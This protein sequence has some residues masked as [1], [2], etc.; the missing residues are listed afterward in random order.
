SATLVTWRSLPALPTETVLS[1]SAVEPW[2]SAT[3]LVPVT[4]AP[5]PMAV[6]EAALTLAPSPIATAL[7][8]LEPMVVLAPTAVL[9][10]A[11][12]EALPPIAVSLGPAANAPPPTATPLLP[13]A[14]EPEPTATPLV[15][16]PTLAAS[17]PSTLTRSARRG[18]GCERGDRRRATWVRRG[19]VECVVQLAAV[20]GIRAGGADRTGG[21]VAHHRAVLAGQRGRG[22]G[23]VVVLHRIGDAA[24]DIADA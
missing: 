4:E 15:P 5:C 11:P 8:A 16:S 1:R 10:S 21:E 23:L 3:L 12:T 17:P 6:P 20:D 13:L 18:D 14:L 19:L 7:V 24:L 9:P 22:L 2:P